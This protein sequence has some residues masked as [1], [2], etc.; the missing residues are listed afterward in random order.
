M[1][2][3]RKAWSASLLLLLAA[4]SPR[5]AAQAPPSL[6]ARAATVISL[7]SRV[8]DTSR[9]EPAL[10]EALRARPRARPRMRSCW[11]NSP[12]R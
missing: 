8:I 5:L 1:P 12:R 2:G 3:M 6:E 7:K 10:P 11:S 4:V 9:P